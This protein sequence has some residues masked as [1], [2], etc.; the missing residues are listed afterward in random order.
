ME[1]ARHRLPGALRLLQFFPGHPDNELV[2]AYTP[3][4]SRDA[5]DVVLALV[6]Q[7][8]ENFEG[9]AGDL[10]LVIGVKPHPRHVDVARFGCDQ[11]LHCVHVLVVV[12]ATR[13]GPVQVL[14][15]LRCLPGLDTRANRT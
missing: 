15:S 3:L 13:H 7:L 9:L 4:D 6:L 1:H 14:M 12:V 11:V 8:L 2:A 10:E 5:P